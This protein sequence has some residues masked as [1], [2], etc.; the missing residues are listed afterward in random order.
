MSKPEIINLKINDSINSLIATFCKKNYLYHEVLNILN[1][2]ALYVYELST[3]TIEINIKS[4]EELIELLF[5][6]SKNGS[7]DSEAYN[8]ILSNI[9]EYTLEPQQ[10]NALKKILVKLFD[11][12]IS[13][14]KIFKRLESVLL[15]DALKQ[16]DT[17]VSEI[18]LSFKEALFDVASRP[19]Q[20]R[21][22][23]SLPYITGDIQ[24][25]SNKFIG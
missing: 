10:S 5:Q 22:I 1:T 15:L 16:S 9:T 23:I 25:I 18:E 8:L 21:N 7:L 12:N 3:Q 17:S 19:F 14:F 11:V 13:D 6:K 20:Y 24:E 4:Y 2:K